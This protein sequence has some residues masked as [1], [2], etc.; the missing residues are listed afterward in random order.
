MFSRY[1]LLSLIVSCAASMV[2]CKSTK[3]A[4]D[5]GE[6]VTE[7]SQTTP[8]TSPASTSSAPSMTY[9][10]EG[11]S[12]LP[13]DSADKALAIVASK[14]GIIR[15]DLNGS[16]EG[17][18][19][20]E[21]NDVSHCIMDHRTDVLW[22]V[23]YN[24]ARDRSDWYGL[25]MKVEGAAPVHFGEAVPGGYAIELEYPDR[26][27]H[28]VHGELDG[29]VAPMLSLA[30]EPS[31]RPF[32]ACEG[33]AAWAC[34]ED[35]EFTILSEELREM[36]AAIHA[37]S[38]SEVAWLNTIAS[39]DAIPAVAD[40]SEGPMVE[41]VPEDRCLEAPGDCGFSVTVPGTPY[42]KVI[43]H[44]DRGDYYHESHQFYDSSTGEF[45]DP[46]HEGEKK[47]QEVP[48]ADD[49]V[50]APVGGVIA[51][52]AEAYAT[53]EWLISFER[54]QIAEFQSVCGWTEPSAKF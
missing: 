20:Y 22:F 3:P 26:S 53:G 32:I 33:D 18:F 52:G 37:T 43:T 23:R 21:G 35:D 19:L 12:R 45:F 34:Y 28:G 50:V 2:A 14:D 51:P 27:R 44:N 30:G 17:A 49:E 7:T 40:A 16:S 13:D 48:F 36:K 5:D 8:S 10:R 54:G 9:A 38:L 4:K 24:E 15:V 31:L 42:L 29:V 1:V 41:G 46:M 39:R 47:R 25:D 6:G 11:L